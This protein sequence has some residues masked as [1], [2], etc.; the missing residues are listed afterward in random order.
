[1]PVFNAVIVMMP[2]INVLFSDCAAISGYMPPMVLFCLPFL[3]MNCLNSMLCAHIVDLAHGVVKTS[4][5]VPEVVCN[6]RWKMTFR[7]NCKK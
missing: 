7:L 5:A 3:F 6:C 2:L 4:A 1:V